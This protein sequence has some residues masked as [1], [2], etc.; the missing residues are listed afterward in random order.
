MMSMRAGPAPRTLSARLGRPAPQVTDAERAADP[1]HD[2]AGQERALRNE[3]CT[4]PARDQGSEEERRTAAHQQRKAGE[5]A[6]E[7]G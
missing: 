2:Q 4:Q 5:H 1:E 3:P 6:R 7:R